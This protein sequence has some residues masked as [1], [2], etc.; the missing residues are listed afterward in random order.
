MSVDDSFMLVQNKIGR[1]PVLTREEERALALRAREGDCAARNRLIESNLRYVLK[2]IFKRWRLDRFPGLQFG[3]LISEGCMGLIKALRTFDPS[4]EA[5][6]LSYADSA[7]KQSVSRAIWDWKRNRHESLDEPAFK[8][9]SDGSKKDS[10]PS[11]EAD[12]DEICACE[13]VKGLLSFLSKREAEIIRLRYW[14]DLPY[15]EVGRQIGISKERVRQSE[16]KALRKL[17]WHAKDIVRFGYADF[18]AQADG[19]V[20]GH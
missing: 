3:D 6:F 8:D 4:R 2:V 18:Q 11:E 9:E 17:R 14:H 5:R 7:I 10:L 1:K 16:N 19:G 20:N 12:T 13:Q 15:E